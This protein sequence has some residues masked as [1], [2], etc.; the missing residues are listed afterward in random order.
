MTSRTLLSRI[1]LVR[2]SIRLAMCL[3]LL[4]GISLVPL[5]AVRATPTGGT[6]WVWGE[7]SFGQLGDNTYNNRLAPVSISSLSNSIAFAGGEGRHDIRERR[8][9][10]RRRPRWRHAR[11]AR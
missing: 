9:R 10:L 3:V 6:A 11:P 4:V 5:R 8:M 7:N 1:P 2:H